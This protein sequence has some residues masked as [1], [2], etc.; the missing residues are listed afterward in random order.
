MMTHIKTELSMPRRNPLCSY[1][2]VLS[3][4][5]H[6][7]PTP[8]A[9]IRVLWPSIPNQFLSQLITER[10]SE[11]VWSSCKTVSQFA[12]CHTNSAPEINTKGTQARTMTQSRA[13][14]PACLLWGNKQ[15][16]TQAQTPKI[17]IKLLKTRQKVARSIFSRSRNEKLRMINAAIT[18]LL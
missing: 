7:R 15:N 9:C 4:G 14:S 13:Q 11:A 10:P 18:P 5:R 17:L 6:N 8:V 12:Y 3:K 2:L 1:A 16:T